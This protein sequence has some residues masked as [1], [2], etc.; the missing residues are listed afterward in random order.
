MLL[1][2]S[3]YAF[4]CVSHFL[5][6]PLCLRYVIQCEQNFATLIERMFYRQLCFL[7]I[8]VEELDSDSDSDEELIVKDDE[9]SDKKNDVKD[10]VLDSIFHYFRFC[11]FCNFSC[12]KGREIEIGDCSIECFR[13]EVKILT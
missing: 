3:I 10:E 9:E 2:V 11:K 6:T 12:Q 1:I 7:L 5:S 8:A 4:G 13:Q